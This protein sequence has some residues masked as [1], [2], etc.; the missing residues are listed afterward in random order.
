MRMFQLAT[1]RKL[2]PSKSIMVAAASVTS[3]MLSS[4]PVVSQ[5]GPRSYVSIA[6][7]FGIA[8]LQQ[9]LSLGELAKGLE[10]SSK[11]RSSR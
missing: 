2:F 7:D 8:P 11:S 5:R 1:W 3:S 10:R 6:R 9:L 4:T